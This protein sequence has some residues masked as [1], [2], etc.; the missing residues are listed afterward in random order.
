MSNEIIELQVKLDTLKSMR[1]LRLDAQRKVDA[2][3]SQETMIQNGL[4]E[5]L[6]THPE[7]NGVIGTTHKGI[8]RT[9]DQPIVTDRGVLQDYIVANDAWDLINYNL[10]A[11]AVRT[12]W[13]DEVELPGV[14]TVQQTK[15]SVTKL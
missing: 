13:D 3:K 15:L 10:S 1:D 7:I 8:L 14:G 5:Y 2:M 6:T 4:I 9:T 12:R 11:P